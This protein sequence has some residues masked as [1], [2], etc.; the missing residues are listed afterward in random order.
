MKK[1][2][3]AFT[4]CYLQAFDFQRCTN[5]AVLFLAHC[6]FVFMV[7]HIPLLRIWTF[8]DTQLGK[9]LT[10]IATSSTFGPP[11]SPCISLLSFKLQPK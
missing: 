11:I 7:L 6:V 1:H 10:Y 8:S 2:L 5:S 9:K 4:L 3:T